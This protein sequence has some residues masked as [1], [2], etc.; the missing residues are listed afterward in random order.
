[1]KN[2]STTTSAIVMTLFCA[3]FPPV[4]R[5]VDASGA[6][7]QFDLTIKDLT[8]KFLTFYNEAAKEKASPDRRWEL[9]KKDYDFAAVPP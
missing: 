7:P 1:M 2:R 3:T 5:G 6:L 9:W 8:P 4:G